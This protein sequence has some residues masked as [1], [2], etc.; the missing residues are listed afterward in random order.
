MAKQKLFEVVGEGDVESLR[1]ILKN[2]KDTK[3]YGELLLLA[4]DRNFPEVAILLLENK[5]DPNV[6]DD[7]GNTPLFYAVAYHNI[8]SIT[9]LLRHKANPDIQNCA[10]K[11]AL[12]IS[13]QLV[14]KKSVKLLLKHQADPNIPDNYGETPIFYLRTPEIFTLLLEHNADIDLKNKE[15]HS[16]RYL[17]EEPSLFEYN[18]HLRNALNDYLTQ[19]LQNIKVADEGVSVTERYNQVSLLAEEN[20]SSSAQDMS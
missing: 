18:S 20:F 6:R 4:L 15:G 5:A 2:S 11:T 16:I 9:S 10:G 7:R 19:Q 13:A 8:Q 14:G 3:D 12:H 17:L 1:K